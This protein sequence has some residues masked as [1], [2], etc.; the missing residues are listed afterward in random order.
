MNNSK[1]KILYILKIPPPYTGAPMMNER[2]I[3]SNLLNKHFDIKGIMVSY[4][5]TI[6]QLGKNNLSKAKKVVIYFKS[7]LHKLVSFSPDIVYIHL[8]PS[9]ISFFR[10]SIFTLFARLFRKTVVLHLRA[11]GVKSKYRSSGIVLRLYYKMVINRIDV[12]CLSEAAAEDL[13]YF[14]CRVHIINNGIPIDN[15]FNGD[16]P[17]NKTPKI[18][19]LSNLIESKGVF[20]YIY[21]LEYLKKSGRK[22]EGIIV[23]AEA[24]INKVELTQK[25]EELG[26][27]G[28]VS[29]KGP[30]Y[31][32]KKKEILKKSDIFVFPTYFPVET[33]GSVNIEAMQ[34]SLAI[35]STRFSAVP[36][37][38]D[39]G[40]NGLLVN[41][42]SPKEISTN[43]IS[44]ID[45]PKYRV[46]LGRN[47]R[48]KYLAC[49]T[50][51]IYENNLKNA[52][53]EIL[54]NS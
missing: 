7:Y 27:T 14:N 22:F 3:N 20:D 16:K 25:I 12:I 53:K 50:F 13:C 47:A 35:I 11:Y 51:N 4:S 32:E 48:E 15:T 36:E 24:D 29:Y 23:G 31:G 26:L 33:F 39:D 28:L 44:L 9:G 19:F 5:T 41:I 2:V 6:T 38:I 49:Y 43:L 52:F 37:I 17:K 8:S 40:K 18:L 10:D 21:S 1:P 30:L 46:E 45:N 54:K 34:Y 42:K